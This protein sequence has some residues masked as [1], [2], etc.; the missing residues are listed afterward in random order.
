VAL[1][2]LERLRNP[3]VTPRRPGEFTAIKQFEEAE[4]PLLRAEH[5]RAALGAAAEPTKLTVQDSTSC[6]TRGKT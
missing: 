5:P 2:R 6:M 3:S 4:Q 1:E